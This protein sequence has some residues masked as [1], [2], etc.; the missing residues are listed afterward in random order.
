MRG[1][2]TLAAL[3]SGRQAK[4]Y[5]YF[6]SDVLENVIYRRKGYAGASASEIRKAKELL[7]LLK[8]NSGRT[9]GYLVAVNIKTG[10]IVLIPWPRI[11][12]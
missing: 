5:K 9:T 2:P 11:M 10:R 12:K 6:A 7:E 3:S 1:L 4:G 8:R